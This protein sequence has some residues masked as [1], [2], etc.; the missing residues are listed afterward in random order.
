MWLWGAKILFMFLYAN[1]QKSIMRS[2]FEVLTFHPAIAANNYHENS[3]SGTRFLPYEQL[4]VNLFSSKK[5][6]QIGFVNPAFLIRCQNEPGPALWKRLLAYRNVVYFC[7][8]CSIRRY[9][10]GEMP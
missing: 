4:I 9:Y 5:F 2:I 8:Q 7:F 10:F 1:D 6:P 3:H